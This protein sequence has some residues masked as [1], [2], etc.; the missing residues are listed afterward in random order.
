MNFEAE[1]I[2]KRREDLERLLGTQTEIR[3]GFIEHLNVMRYSVGGVFADL[4]NDGFTGLGDFQKAE[5]VFCS[6]LL[7]TMKPTHLSPCFNPGCSECRARRAIKLQRRIF[8][9]LLPI[10]IFV[11]WWF[12]KSCQIAFNPQPNNPTYQTK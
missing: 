4:S 6:N 3:S 11:L 5:I 9:G 1:R 8:F 7:H 12:Y 10:F 2:S